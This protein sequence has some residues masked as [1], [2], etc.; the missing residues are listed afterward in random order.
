MSDK[1]GF[2]KPDPKGFY[3]PIAEEESVR[4]LV[5]TE[6]TVLID[7]LNS[8]EPVNSRKRGRD[9]DKEPV[10]PS[11]VKKK[12]WQMFRGNVVPDVDSPDA[13]ALWSRI[14]QEQGS[15][16]TFLRRMAYHHSPTKTH[17]G[18]LVTQTA[19]HYTE[20]SAGRGAQA[21]VSFAKE[22]FLSEDKPVTSKIV[23]RAQ[24][25]FEPQQALLSRVPEIE[26]GGIDYPLEC[27]TML[28][29]HGGLYYGIFETSDGDL[30]K[31][32]Y[33][34]QLF[35]V[36]F[37][38]GQLISAAG[39]LKALHAAGLIHRDVKGMNTLFKV[40]GRGK[41]TD[42]DLL[43]LE[44][45]EGESHGVGATPEYAASFIWADIT[46]QKKRTESGRITSWGHQS[47][48]SDCFAFGVMLQKDVLAKMVIELSQ[49]HH[50]GCSLKQDLAPKIVEEAK[51]MQ[52]FTDEEL[53]ELER[54][55]PGQRIVYRFPNRALQKPG[56]VSIFHSRE[57]DYATILNAISKLKDIL[58]PQEIAGLE[59]YAALAYEL[60]DPDPAKIMT[61][62]ALEGRLM[63]IEALFSHSES[64]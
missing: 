56:Y 5:L 33:A 21:T 63:E 28:N 62:A 29:S 16:S 26:R 9:E 57:T 35:P 8:P 44:R 11:P 25:D 40:D 19:M 17:R 47:Q 18:L 13:R 14:K 54:Q 41:L 37:I 53:H 39:G 31:I 46:D 10:T 61:A 58:S 45:A 23:K 49:K 60:Q 34:D 20:R 43:M 38:T 51:Y 32:R 2:I 7:G 52:L 48:A 55:H 22:L 12:T 59:K 15:A 42:F 4:T 6:K 64:S 3:I 1:V 50:V 27:G 24:K 30:T 36:S